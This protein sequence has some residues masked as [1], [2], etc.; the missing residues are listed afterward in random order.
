MVRVVEI[1]V[2]VDPAS[3]EMWLKKRIEKA[4]IQTFG[5]ADVGGNVGGIPMAGKVR[6]EEVELA[7][8]RSHKFL[9]AA[10]S[11]IKVAS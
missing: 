8:K 11:F 6:I 10:K 3:G 9:I 4:I 1:V 2:K 5:A 7:A